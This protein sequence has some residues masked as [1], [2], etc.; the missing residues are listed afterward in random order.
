MRAWTTIALAILFLIGLPT[1]MAQSVP[2]KGLDLSGWVKVFSC[3]F[4]SPADLKKWNV[5]KRSENANN[6]LQHYTPDACKVSD[7]FLYIEGRKEDTKYDGKVRH[8]TSG[9]LDTRGKFDQQYGRYDIRFKV[10]RGK[11]YW[12]AFWL[13][14][15]DS[16]WPPEIDWMEILGHDPKTLYVTNHYGTHWEG[17]HKEHGAK[18]VKAENPD[19]SEDFHTLTGIWTDREITCFVDGKKVSVSEDGV[20]QQKMF[21]ILNLA[22][23]GDWPGNPTAE[24]VFPGALVVDYLRAYKRVGSK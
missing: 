18:E 20:P 15:S 9:L 17:K 19:Y 2:D 23:G 1:A 8:Y 14:P 12:P 7:G 11:G 21:M 4:D 10:P 16:S 5:I 6:E 22:I 24:T 3:E 13:L